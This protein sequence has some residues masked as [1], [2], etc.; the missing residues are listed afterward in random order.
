M[1]IVVNPDPQRSPDLS[2]RS[3][4]APLL[5]QGSFRQYPCQAGACRIKNIGAGGQRTHSPA[6]IFFITSARPQFLCYGSQ[7][8]FAP[9]C[10]EAAMPS[11][12]LPALPVA[13][14]LEVLQVDAA[15]IVCHFL[16]RLDFSLA[17]HT[18]F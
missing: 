13:G 10:H 11:F 14:R 3:S 9:T 6:P 15:P 17:V 5:D 1:V 8:A 16:S 7:R 18:Y 4:A 2:G 12:T